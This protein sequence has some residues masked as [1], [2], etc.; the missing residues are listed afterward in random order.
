[1]VNWE[2]LT[3]Q[4][5][6]EAFGFLDRLEATGSRKEKELII[7]Q[8]SGNEVFKAL[9]YKAYNPFLKYNLVA[10]GDVNHDINK[11]FEI[12]KPETL[13]R[14]FE[15]L[16][17][18]NQCVLT[19]NEAIGTVNAFFTNECNDDEYKWYSR[20]LL[21]D[22]RS[23]FTAK[24]VN[25]VI[26]KFIPIFECMLA[27]PWDKIKP[28]KRPKHFI[29]EPKLDGYR[30]LG[31]HHVHNS[32]YCTTRNGKPITGFNGIEFDLAK[33]PAGFVFDGEIIGKEDSFGDMQ[34]SVFN[35]EMKEKHGT[36]VIFDVVPIEEFEAG[37]S[38]KTLKERKSQLLAMWEDYVDNFGV[39]ENIEIV[40]W[41]EVE[42]MFTEEEEYD[43]LV[44]KLHD[45]CIKMGY[46]GIMIKDANSYYETKR[47]K[48]WAK[49]KAF[50]DYDLEVV[51]AVEGTGKY[52]GRLG[53]LIV[54]YKGNQL[55]VGSGFTDAERL[56]YWVKQNELIGKVIQVQA[57]EETNNQKGTVSLRFPSFKGFRVDKE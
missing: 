26:K 34:K 16:D 56:E 22:L 32:V 20:V 21:K 24:T 46:E 13:F 9:V 53:A 35:K 54:D 7:A 40:D 47:S 12:S 50:D 41:G 10:Y 19:G 30:D 27:E 42:V 45:K 55:E 52:K 28:E 3:G 5:I 33:M 43:A 48:S 57:Q 39:P 36:L 38:S 31:F 15:I 2:T 4:T 17:L 14:F 8:A 6:E 29:W 51:G 18:L 44:A 11:L 37:K 1:M 49:V 25:K 23:G